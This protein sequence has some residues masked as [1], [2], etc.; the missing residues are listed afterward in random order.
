MIE[1]DPGTLRA[2]ARELDQ[3]ADETGNTGDER[4]AMVSGFA[5]GFAATLRTRAIETE[6]AWNAPTRE[7]P[8]I[9]RVRANNDIRA[10][11][12]DD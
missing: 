7:L 2:L 4:K 12:L 5:A 1:Y 6:L 9:A 11:W 3:V 8:V 10:A